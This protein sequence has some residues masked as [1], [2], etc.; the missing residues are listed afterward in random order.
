MCL[1]DAQ[2]IR[3]RRVCPQK[4]GKH[5][6]AAHAWMHCPPEGSTL[7]RGATLLFVL[8]RARTAVQARS[9]VRHA[10]DG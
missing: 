2:D 10:W 1:E 9:K 3:K 5:T 6:L 7:P 4:S 8:G